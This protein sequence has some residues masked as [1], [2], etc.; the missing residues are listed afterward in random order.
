MTID[1]SVNDKKYFTCQPKRGVFV[2]PERVTVGDYPE[3]D[4]FADVMD[5]EEEL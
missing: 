2:R 5:S 4:E 1:Y 3:V